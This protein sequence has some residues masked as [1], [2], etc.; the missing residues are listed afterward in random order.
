MTTEPTKSTAA[1]ASEIDALKTLLWLIA[2]IH[3]LIGATLNFVPGA[4]DTIADA[5]GA[6]VNWTPEF[7]YI[8]KPLGAFMV[9]LGI[10][11]ACAARNPLRCRPIIYGFV[12]LFVA[13]ALQRF[14]FANEIA[15]VFGI[16]S[17]RNFVNAGFFLLLALGLVALERTASR[18]FSTDPA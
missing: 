11:A 6:S 15:E 4:A 5:Y 10:M 8:L 3:I 17:G 12:V 16:D 13:R 2:A 1:E 9:A 14:A 18:K 7:S